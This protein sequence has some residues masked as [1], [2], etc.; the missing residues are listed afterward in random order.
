MLPSSGKDAAAAAERA[1]P[2]SVRDGGRAWAGR[3]QKQ[4]LQQA[5][6][7]GGVSGRTAAASRAAF[8][9]PWG[10]EARGAAVGVR[11]SKGAVAAA[12]VRAPSKNAKSAPGEG[13][14]KDAL[15]SM[16]TKA[17]VNGREIAQDFGGHIQVCC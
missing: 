13:N 1:T 7:G 14:T 2:A 6:L 4:K 11:S 17:G 15:R 16:A 9:G 5:K 12:A 8:V 3:E 10:E